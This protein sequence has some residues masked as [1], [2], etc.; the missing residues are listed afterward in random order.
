MLE[1]FPD[2]GIMTDEYLLGDVMSRPILSMRERSMIIIAA[3]MMVRHEGTRG[4]MNRALNVGLSREEVIEIILQAAPYGNWPV[5]DEIFSLIERAY[6]GYLQTVKENPFSKV[7]SQPGL[8]LRERTMVT[9]ACLI[10][11]RF[12]DRLK[13][14]MH[15][16]LNIGLSREEILE[17]IMQTTAFSGW[18]VGVEA[19]RVAK[20]VFSTKE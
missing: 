3:L 19:I 1:V 12:G 17:V 5:G 2:I 20:D 14:H 9:M 6:P 15:H 11:R 7:W 13:A 4:H 8:S 18:P 16:A 10:A